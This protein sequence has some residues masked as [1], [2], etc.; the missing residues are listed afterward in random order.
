[1]GRK[2]GLAHLH[3]LFQQAVD[4]LKRRFLRQILDCLHKVLAVP[5]VACAATK[6]AAYL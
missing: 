2:L 6:V 1:V 5:S 4:S 3:A